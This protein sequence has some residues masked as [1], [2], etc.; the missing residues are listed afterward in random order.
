MS[1]QDGASRDEPSSPA[2]QTTHSI[3]VDGPETTPQTIALTERLLPLALARLVQRGLAPSTCE[4]S[5]TLVDDARIQELNRTYRGIDAPTDVLSF[6]QIEGDGIDPWNVPPG[7]VVPIG[8]IVISIPRMRAQAVDYGHS[9][10]RELGFLLI[11]GLLHVLGFDH[12]TPE[13][14]Q[15]MR[16]A[17]EDVLAAAGL[18]RDAGANPT[19]A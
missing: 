10:S 15:E 8:D 5:V 4:V 9:E 18:T 2:T 12:E 19:S 13:D 6:S 1:S 11:H 3:L 16:A 14:A 7:Y 17:E